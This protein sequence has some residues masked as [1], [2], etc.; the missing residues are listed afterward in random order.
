M[1]FEPDNI[2]TDNDVTVLLRNILLE[3]KKLNLM[4]AE[5]SG[6]KVRDED[7]Q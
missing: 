6:Q 5:F 2:D 1:S 7:V 4:T 3:L